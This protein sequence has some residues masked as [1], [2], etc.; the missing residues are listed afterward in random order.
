MERFSAETQKERSG[1][2]GQMRVNVAA[3]RC[4]VKTGCDRERR[5]AGASVVKGRFDA[6]DDGVK[7][8][9]RGA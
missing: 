1:E 5:H 4:Y 3:E 9:W 7:D 6:I 2:R 8:A